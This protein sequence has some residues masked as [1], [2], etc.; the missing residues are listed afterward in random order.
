M[1]EPLDVVLVGWDDVGL[2]DATP[3]VCPNLAALRAAGA[4]LPFAFSNPVCSQSR[5]VILF[6]AMGRTLGILTAMDALD[7]SSPTPPA[8]WTTLAHA[9]ADAGWSTCLVG[10]WHLGPAPLGG[11]PGLAPLQRGYQA[12]RAGTFANIGGPQAPGRSFNLWDRVDA[13]DVMGVV[14]SVSSRYATLAQVEEAE[15]WWAAAAGAPRF[16]HVALND[17]HG[18]YSTPIPAELLAGWPQP[19]ALSSQRTRFLAKLRAADTALGR[20]LALAGPS[21]SVAL[22]YSDNGTAGNAVAPGV[23]PERVKTTTYEGGIRVPMAARWPGVAP[24]SSLVQLVHLVDVP[25]ALLERVGVPRPAQ[26]DGQTN[27]RN[28]VVSEAELADGTLEQAVRT[29]THKLR[30]TTPPGGARAEE[31]YDLSADPGETSPLD[32]EAPEHQQLLLLL[33][34]ALYGSGG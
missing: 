14:R 15:A 11:D 13:D 5:A 12:W 6:G 16:L 33:R 7:P 32:L 24:G 28:H 2:V 31:L 1:P 20:V 27:P 22:V 19:S 21:T 26:W 25:A 17:P 8:S 29:E 9:L 34:L 23:D 3:D 10:K 30:A 18:P 4:D